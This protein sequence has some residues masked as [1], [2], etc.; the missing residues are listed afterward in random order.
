[1][2]QILQHFIFA[3]FLGAVIGID[4]EKSASFFQVKKFAGIRT[5]TLIGLLGVLLALLERISVFLFIGILSA[6]I[7]LIV[8]SYIGHSFRNNQNGGTSELASI[9]V[10]IAGYFVGTNN[11]TLA[12]MIIMAT[13]ILLFGKDKI[14]DFANAVSSEEM[15]SIIQFV[16]IAFIVL[17]LLPNQFY[18][19]YESFNPYLIW[20]MIVLVSGISF[21]SYLAIKLIGTDKGISLS[22]FLGGF[23]SSTA[24]TLAFSQRSKKYEKIVNPF[25][26]GIIISSTAMFF[27]L[28]V[29][30]SVV[31]PFLMPYVVIPLASA[32]ITGLIISGIFWYL[33][34]REKVN[35]E[36]MLDP[37]QIDL[38]KPLDLVAALKFGVIFSIVIF[39]SKFMSETFGDS[40]IYVTSVVS[41]LV[42][43]D[44][45]TIT[46]SNLSKNMNVTPQL[47]ATGI[48]IAAYT[49]TFMKAIYATALGSRAV[50]IRTT[51]SVLV[52]ISVGLL[53]LFFI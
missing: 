32:G 37:E 3:M 7:L 38:G 9:I 42:D 46:L 49:N 22:G 14:H 13:A 36:K 10:L 31:N 15:K 35:S 21:M 25:V 44:A 17:P 43:T 18:G 8:S 19:P 6:Y 53:S 12:S 45:I 48:A 39:T 23:V 33:Q 20:T 41:S 30:I 29:A 11:Y 52:M 16:V 1:M 47:A 26:F 5:F 40:G 50:A 34:D 24:V 27:R 28:M 4:R 2:L 51:V